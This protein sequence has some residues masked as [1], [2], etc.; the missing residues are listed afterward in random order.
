M[1]SFVSTICGSI[2]EQKLRWRML[3]LTTLVIGVRAP[4]IPRNKQHSRTV[5]ELTLT[6]FT[7]FN[8]Q[9]HE[10]ALSHVA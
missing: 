1:P 6:I 4:S 7:Q 5:E 8:I 10:S 9:L 3:Y 2:Q